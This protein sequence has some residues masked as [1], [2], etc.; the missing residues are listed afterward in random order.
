MTCRTQL[1][2]GLLPHK[3]ILINFLKK[4]LSL[5]MLSVPLGGKANFYL[6]LY[7]ILLCLT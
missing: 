4:I 7:D 2:Q 5:E 3:Q 1:Q 6:Y